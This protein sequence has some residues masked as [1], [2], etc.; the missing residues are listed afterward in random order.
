MLERRLQE[1]GHENEGY[2]PWQRSSAHCRFLPRRVDSDLPKTAVADRE[3]CCHGMITLG[4]EQLDNYQRNAYGT[5]KWAANYAGHNPVAWD[6]DLLEADA[7]I[8]DDLKVAV[9]GS[10]R[11]ILYV[12]GDP[13]SCDKPLYESIFPTVTVQPAGSSDEVK[14]AVNKAAA[15]ESLHWLNVYGLIRPEPSDRPRTR[16]HRP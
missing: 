11:T 12:E 7:D 13:S 15:A 16:H 5:T 1:P 8:D 3:Y 6:A 4:V 10:R 14:T 2:R 9:W